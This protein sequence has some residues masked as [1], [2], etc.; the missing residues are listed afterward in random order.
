MNIGDILTKAWQ[1]TWKYKILW[2]FGILASC[3]EGSGGGNGGGGGSGSGVDGSRFNGEDLGLPFESWIQ[4][5][6]RY[7]ENFE[8]Q[9]EQYVGLIAVILMVLCVLWLAAVALGTMGRIGLIKGALLADREAELISFGELWQESGRHFWQV[10]SLWL[11]LW[12]ASFI[13]AVILMLIIAAG[14]VLTMGLLVACLLPL[15]CL[16]I[17]L[18]WLLNLVFEQATI[19]IIKEE[20]GIMDALQRAW[21]LIR[22][23]IGSYILMALILFVLQFALGLI[24][25]LPI[26]LVALPALL[27]LFIGSGDS[28]RTTLIISGLCFV[29]YMPVLIVLGGILRT[30]I[31]TAWTLTFSRL[32]D[33]P[34]LQPAQPE[35][36]DAY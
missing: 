15:L 24:I 11:I 33:K 12:L 27:G 35:M 17:P 26:L 1:I 28:I 7:F 23:N 21:E 25:T 18:L 16:L 5:A 22:A 30:Y 31:W 10:I 14:A 13:V 8:R 32:S 29:V 9:P 4:E 36:L 6:V 34:A 20:R 2:I 3:V 19:A